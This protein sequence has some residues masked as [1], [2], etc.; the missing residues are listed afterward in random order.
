[1]PRS[2]AAP[3]R[4]VRST[5]RFEAYTPVERRGYGY[6][7][8]PLLWRDRV[9]GWATCEGGAVEVD[10]IGSAPRVR[11]YTAALEAEIVR[12]KK[13]LTQA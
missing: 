9:I 12:L 5:Y 8:M 6:Y 2:G 4:P 7:A 13:F 1:M 10:Y 3:A 11:F